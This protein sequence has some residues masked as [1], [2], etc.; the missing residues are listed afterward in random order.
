[1]RSDGVAMAWCLLTAAS[2]GG[3][4]DVATGRRGST[5]PTIVSEAEDAG[6]SDGGRA[7][8]L[9]VGGDLPEPVPFEE[10]GCPPVS[11]LPTLE[12]CDPLS[13]SATC[14]VG[15]SCFP[16]VSY[17]SGPCGVERFGAV[18]APAGQGTQGDPCSEQACAAEHICVSTGRGTQCVRLCGFAAGAPSVCAPGL[19]CL[20][21]DIEGFG[22]CL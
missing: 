9:P 2:C 22:G 4:V 5:P 1:M 8:T 14:P 19:L 12:E 3:Q 20:P 10:P 15:E 7:P 11:A 16:F 17:P 6:A 13:S 21:I 18:C